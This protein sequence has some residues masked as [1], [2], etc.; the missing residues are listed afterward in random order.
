[1]EKRPW[2]YSFSGIGPSFQIIAQNDHITQDNPILCY[3]R[4]NIRK[5]ITSDFNHAEATLLVKSD[6][7][8]GSIRRPNQ[9]C[10]S[11]ASAQ[12]LQEKAHDLLSIPAPTQIRGHCDTHEL[13][14]E[15]PNQ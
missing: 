9:E 1:M 4:L 11:P 2:E 5:V 6:V 12:F 8:K 3:R 13:R 10:M 7:I 14:N 15:L